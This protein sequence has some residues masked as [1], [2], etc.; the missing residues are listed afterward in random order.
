VLDEVLVTRDVDDPQVGRSLRQVE[1]SEA[2]VD[3]DAAGLFLGQAVG[4]GAGERAHQRALAMIDVAGGGEDVG[5]VGHQ[6]AERIASISCTSWRG[7]TVRR[8]NLN[9]AS[10]T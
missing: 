4:V 2:Q 6:R 5:A 7:K 10:E 8:S 9:R 3:G 1:V